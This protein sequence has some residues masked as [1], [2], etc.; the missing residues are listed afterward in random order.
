M[1]PQEQTAFDAMREAVEKFVAWSKAECNHY[2]TTFWER[3]EMLREL[4][5]SA[6]AALAAAKEVQCGY[7]E[8]TGNCTFNPCCRAT[9]EQ[10]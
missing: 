9:K 1:T 5:A 7:D 2:G 8:T 10:T 4:D 6:E 3:V